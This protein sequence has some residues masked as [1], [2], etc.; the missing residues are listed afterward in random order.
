[1]DRVRS[2]FQT[3]SGAA[4]PTSLA[5]VAVPAPRSGARVADVGFRP[6]AIISRLEQG[7]LFLSCCGEGPLFGARRSGQRD[8]A[9]D[10]GR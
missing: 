9:Q 10:L 7:F 8:E 5:G 3:A 1:M 2:G 6:E 4:T